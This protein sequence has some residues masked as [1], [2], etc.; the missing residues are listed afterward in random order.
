M[1]SPPAGTGRVARS[2]PRREAH[3]NWSRENIE[4]PC[5]ICPSARMASRPMR[6]GSA[7]RLG[8]WR[9]IEN[10]GI[11]AGECDQ[12]VREYARARKVNRSGV[13]N[14]RKM[15]GQRMEG[16]ALIVQ[17]EHAVMMVSIG[18]RDGRFGRRVPVARRPAPFRTHS[19]C[20]RRSKERL[21]PPAQPRRVP[22]GR[23]GGSG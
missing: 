12:L 6:D 17:T 22:S 10:T 20:G 23:R 7:Q 13:D 15:S 9:A 3:A 5:L 2:C 16:A 1:H 19:A 11:A 18:I 4:T 21:P 14:M 8:S